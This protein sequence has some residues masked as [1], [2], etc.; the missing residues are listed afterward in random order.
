LGGWSP[1]LQTGFH[2]SRPTYC[3][4]SS[5][6]AIS[7]TGL[8]PSVTTL[9][10]VFHYRCGYILL[11]GPISLATTLGISVDFYSCSYL[12][13]S[14]RCVRFPSLW[15]Q[16]GMATWAGLPHSEICGSQLVCQLPAAY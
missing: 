11:A 8:S 10:R 9:S 1:H 16:D 7:C 14:V 2:V 4:L 13:V 6:A 5:T 12:D 3:K 15:I